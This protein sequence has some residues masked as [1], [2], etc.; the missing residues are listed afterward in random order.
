[1]SYVLYLVIPLI[2]G[3]HVSHPDGSVLLI[4]ILCSLHRIKFFPEG[5]SAYISIGLSIV[6]IIFLIKPII[7]LF[8]EKRVPEFRFEVNLAYQL[9]SISK[10]N[11]IPE[12]VLY[13]E[14]INPIDKSLAY[15]SFK[16]K[17]IWKL[18]GERGKVKTCTFLGNETPL[19]TTR[20]RWTYI[21]S[22]YSD[23]GHEDISISRYDMNAKVNIPSTAEYVVLEELDAS[24]FP[25]NRGTIFNVKAS[26]FSDKNEFIGEKI[27]E[28]L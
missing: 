11:E 2:F 14:M 9:S 19:Q 21:D 20:M 8:T 4:L 18:S 25:R 22:S 27:Q 23:K 16:G 7:Y 1:M 6:L 12:K 10:N 28:G 3:Y 17:L 13:P 15:H 24:D 5:R 26:C